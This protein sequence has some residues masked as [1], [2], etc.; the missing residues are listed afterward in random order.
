VVKIAHASTTDALKIHMKK[1]KKSRAKQKLQKTQKLAKMTIEEQIAF[2]KIQ[3]ETS[4]SVKL[5]VML[6]DYKQKQLSKLKFKAFK[7][8]IIER[9]KDVEIFSQEYNELTEILEELKCLK[10]N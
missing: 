8:I 6:W 4:I 5:G 2:E 9:L 1:L 7:E 3:N 10:V